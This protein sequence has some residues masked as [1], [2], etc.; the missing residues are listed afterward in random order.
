MCERKKQTFKLLIRLVWLI[1]PEEG[2][3]RFCQTIAVIVKGDR[4]T[5]NVLLTRKQERIN[6]KEEKKL[7][8]NVAAN[9][10]NKR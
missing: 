9:F 1:K 2:L 7:K 3:K 5:A 10:S 6:E 4:Q 8:M